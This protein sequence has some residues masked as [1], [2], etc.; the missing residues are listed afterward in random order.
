MNEFMNDR[1]R[2]KDNNY[3]DLTERNLELGELK[4][5]TA[6]TKLMNILIKVF[7][8]V[9]FILVLSFAFSKFFNNDPLMSEFNMNEKPEI[10][11]PSSEREFTIN[12]EGIEYS[13]TPLA[14]YRIFGRVVAKNRYPDDFDFAA[15][16]APYDVG[17]AHGRLAKKSNIRR[18][19]FTFGDR[20]LY[21]HYDDKNPFSSDF[22]QSH[23]DNV[24]AIHANDRVLEALEK[25]KDN[26]FIIMEGIL[27]NVDIRAG[28]DVDKGWVWESSLVHGTDECKVMYIKR[29]TLAN[30]IYE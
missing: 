18:F 6:Q 14:D 5:I 25:V 27:V 23:L 19:Y 12:Q 30:E 7:F 8:V 4:D 13:L 11:I 9:L 29:I 26:Q 20:C 1:D 17:I 21:Y 3:P 10:K 28:N 16:I 24:H 2:G 15:P 22:M